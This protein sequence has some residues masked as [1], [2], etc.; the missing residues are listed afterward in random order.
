MRAATIFYNGMS[1]V[2]AVNFDADRCKAFN[3]YNVRFM[4]EGILVV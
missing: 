4:Y 1:A 3:F 2:A